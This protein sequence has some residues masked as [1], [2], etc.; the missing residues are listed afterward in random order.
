[1][2]GAAAEYRPYS[3]N[4]EHNLMKNFVMRV[5][6][7]MA[8]VIA[9]AHVDDEIQTPRR[10][11]PGPRAAAVDLRELPAATAGVSHWSEERLGWRLAEEFG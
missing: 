1:M 7:S 10:T 9:I 4:F 6:K 3:G 2:F 11:H 5:E 8:K